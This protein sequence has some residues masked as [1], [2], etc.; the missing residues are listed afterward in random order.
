MAGIHNGPIP[1]KLCLLSD[2]GKFPTGAKVR[3]LG[4]VTNYSTNTAILNL[5]HNHPPGNLSKAQ[6]DVNLL[7]TTLKSNETQIGEW[8]NV[9]GYVTS[10]L[11][12][13]DPGKDKMEIRIQALVLW[14]A[15]SFDLAGYEKSLD[16]KA[17]DE[18]TTKQTV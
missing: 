11:R 10:T 6:V 13:T 7:V 15:G 16:Q 9:M 17:A 2:L 3:F 18:R 4:C 5:E 12:S 1:T 14:P 8:V